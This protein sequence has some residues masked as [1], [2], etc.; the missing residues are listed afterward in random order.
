MR[1]FLIIGSFLCLLLMPAREVIASGV[2][3]S[4]LAADAAYTWSA[5]GGWMRWNAAGEGVAVYERFLAGWIWSPN[6]GWI[7]VGDGTP[8]NGYAYSSETGAD[9]GVN[10][11]EAGALEGY[12]WSPNV[13]WIRF[14]QT[15]GRPRIDM[16]D[17]AFSGYAWSANIGW[18]HLGSVS[19]SADRILLAESF[20]SNDS[21]ND[22]I[23]DSWEQ[24]HFRNLHT[25]DALSDI[26][27]DGHSDVDEAFADTDPLDAKSFFALVEF[28]L[29]ERVGGS[30]IFYFEWTSSPRRTYNLRSAGEL[31]NLRPPFVRPPELSGVP[32]NASGINRETLSI[33]EGPKPSFYQIEVTEPFPSGN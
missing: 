23:E 12:A 11:L 30:S 27:K 15:Y 8:V 5:N 13:G 24:F 21:D 1:G 29:V 32:G 20:A 10:L 6:F 7:S 14:E 26:D 16:A 28:S 3:T 17:G 2:Q 31:S 18:I 25:A 19:P 4:T 9:Y 33:L 22:G